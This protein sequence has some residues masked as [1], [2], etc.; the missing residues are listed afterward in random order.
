MPNINKDS[1]LLTPV[2]TNLAALNVY[3]RPSNREAGIEFALA[4]EQKT[5][6]EEIAVEI[7]KLIQ[8][9]LAELGAFVTPGNPK[10]DGTPSSSIMAALTMT[11]P[12]LKF[13]DPDGAEVVTRSWNFNVNAVLSSEKAAA[14]AEAPVALTWQE[15]KARQQ[16]GKKK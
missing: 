8:P 4:A 16:A 7:A 14:S 12:P 2:Q 10:A 9:R 13:I 1:V 6:R 5:A 11:M 15:M 3:D